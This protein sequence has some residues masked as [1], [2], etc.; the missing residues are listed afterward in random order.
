MRWPGIVVMA[1]LGRGVLV[2]GLSAEEVFFD[3]LS[4]MKLQR[5]VYWIAPLLFDMVSQA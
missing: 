1:C 3:I 5:E 2:H 4:E